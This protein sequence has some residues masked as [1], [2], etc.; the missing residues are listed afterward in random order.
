MFFKLDSYNPV[1]YEDPI[2]LQP[3]FFMAQQALAESG[4]F[5]RQ[6]LVDDKGCVL[7]GMW[8]VP[9]FS[10]ANNA[11]R[12]L[13]CASALM[14]G[15]LT[16]HLKGSIGITTGSIYCGNV[17]SVL[18]R[19]YVGIGDKVNLAARLMGKSKGSIYIDEMSYQQLS[20]EAKAKLVKLKEGLILKGIAEPVFPYT[21]KV[22]TT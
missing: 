13:R 16:L 12:A 19:D 21:L 4:G 22:H 2:T 8:G 20:S 18:R 1:T 5:M 10:H 15:L 6:F 7:I 14:N 11:T 9:S 3:F 17:G